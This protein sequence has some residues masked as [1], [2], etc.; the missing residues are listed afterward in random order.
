MRQD[1][2]CVLFKVQ[3]E[4]KDLKYQLS[5]KAEDYDLTNSDYT[6]KLKILESENNELKESKVKVEHKCE[7]LN[8]YT[9]DL[10][11]KLESKTNHIK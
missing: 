5:K 9:L 7:E 11:T 6:E 2:E 1:H 8:N 10:K 4:V 3:S